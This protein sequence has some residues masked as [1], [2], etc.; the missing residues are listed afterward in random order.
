MSVSSAAS[1]AGRAVGTSILGAA[2]SAPPLWCFPELVPPPF[3]NGLGRESRKRETIWEKGL[4]DAWLL[5]PVSQHPKLLSGD[6]NQ[7]GRPR[8]RGCVER[9]LQGT[10]LL[11]TRARGHRVGMGGGGG[12]IREKASVPPAC[13][14]EI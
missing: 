11:V 7:P 6:R 9:R 3:L 4:G 12:S 10:G 2:G 14:I 13:G 1:L 5:L 8:E